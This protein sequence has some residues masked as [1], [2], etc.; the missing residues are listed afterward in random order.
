MP[1]KEVFVTQD[2]QADDWLMSHPDMHQN[3]AYMDTTWQPFSSTM[4]LQAVEYQV[5]YIRIFCWHMNV[6]KTTQV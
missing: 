6:N 5:K 3:A 1:R 4:N 2:G